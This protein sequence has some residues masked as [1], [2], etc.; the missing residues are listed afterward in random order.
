[1]S[2]KEEKDQYYLV[3]LMQFSHGCAALNE[4]YLREG[5]F[6]GAPR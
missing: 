3:R 6:D 2:H 4:V 1:M 5:G